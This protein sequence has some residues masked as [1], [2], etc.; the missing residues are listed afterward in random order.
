MNAIQQL[1][2]GPMQN[3]QM[4]PEWLIQL[5]RPGQGPSV[6]PVVP[7][8]FINPVA[9]EWMRGG[10]LV[11]PAEPYVPKGL[12]HPYN[13]WEQPGYEWMRP[14]QPFHNW[15]PAL[16]NE[17]G[18]RNIAPGLSQG[19]VPLNSQKD[20][21]MKWLPNNYSLVPPPYE[22]EEFPIKDVMTDSSDL[23]YKY[24]ELEDLVFELNKNIPNAGYYESKKNKISM[25]PSAAASYPTSDNLL[26]HEIQHAINTM[27]MRVGE[28]PKNYQYP[29][30]E[31][32]LL[33]YSNSYGGDLNRARSRIN[34]IARR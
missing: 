6:G 26:A 28:K 4:T 29:L 23:M 14:G 19:L 10:P 2:G 12:E 33:A 8:P 7:Q 15:I 18:A 9:P 27:F 13:Q 16:P 32:E 1:F 22:N 3:T 24:P 11:H 31:D 20:N 21:P 34:Q 17:Q 25:T 30:S 5:M